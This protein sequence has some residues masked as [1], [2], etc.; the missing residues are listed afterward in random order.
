MHK[1]FNNQNI[2]YYFRYNLINFNLLESLRNNE[3]RNNE[4]YFNPCQRF[5][6]KIFL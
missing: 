2:N 6:I 5:T 4:D 3:D 1:K